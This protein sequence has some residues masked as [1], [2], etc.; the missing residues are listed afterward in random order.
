M[1]QSESLDRE[2]QRL[3]EIAKTEGEKNASVL[4]KKRKE[5]KKEE[6]SLYILHVSAS[7]HL[8]RPLWL[9]PDV[10]FIIYPASIGQYW[11]RLAALLPYWQKDNGASGTSGSE[12][13]E[14]AVLLHIQ[15]GLNLCLHS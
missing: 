13:E 7:F 10:V 6:K 4:L 9:L 5:K 11:S 12:K 8:P 3:V 1:R 2:R 14:A 15:S